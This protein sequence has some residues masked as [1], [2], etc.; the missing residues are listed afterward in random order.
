[1]RSP[2][3]LAPKERKNAAHGAS[4]GSEREKD[5]TSPQSGV[6]ELCPIP[7]LPHQLEVKISRNQL[8]ESPPFANYAK[9][10]AT[11]L[12]AVECLRKILRMI[13][14]V[15]S[16]SFSIQASKGVYALLLGS[17]LSTA[18]GIPTGWDVT[19]DLIRKTAASE[20]IECGSDPEAWYRSRY[21]RPA[22]YSEI[23]D[24]LAKTP[25]D[26]TN[27][28]ST[29]F[30]PSARDSE[31]EGKAPTAAHKSIA[32]LVAKGYL[33]VLVTTNFDRLLELA[34]ENEGISPTVIST[35]DAA[36]GALP[37]AHARCTVVKVN[38]DYRDTRIKNTLAE[39]EAYETEMDRLLD[40]I[41]DEY[42]LIIC[43]W[44]ATWDKAL[45]RA[46]LRCPNRR[47]TTYWARRT[48]LTEQ[49]RA[50][51]NHRQAIE[52]PIESADEFFGA[53]ETKL[54][55]I[56]RYSEPHPASAKLAIAS[57]K[58]FIAEDRYRIQLHDLVSSEAEDVVR[59]ISQLPVSMPALTVEEIFERLKLY[60]ATSDTLVAML[61]HGSFWGGAR[62]QPLW[63]KT[64]ARLSG[65]RGLAGGMT[66]LLSL[67][68]YPACL[69]FYALGLGAIAAGKY[70]TLVTI[71][72]DTITQVEGEEKPLISAVLPWSVLDIGVARQLPGYERDYTPIN[73]RLFEVLRD[74]V[75]DYLPTDAE[76]EDAFDRFEYLTCL[77][78]LDLRMKKSK[79]VHAPAG[80]FAW[81]HQAVN[82][83]DRISKES[84]ATGEQWPPIKSR[85]FASLSRFQE[86]EAAYNDH[87]LAKLEW[88]G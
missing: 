58:K 34:L 55:A 3:R 36:R 4:R 59:S 62:E 65:M 16:L 11:R 41:F 80:R 20:G 52:I 26:R 49:A 71:C 33:Q 27:L 2:Q 82:I 57:L 69:L 21:G 7:C 63:A 83:V 84:A 48:S 68:A 79:M 46:V 87:I 38:G 40:R 1:V 22:N 35:A 75:R 29:Y 88:Y 19:L 47:F 56:E 25:A 45:C 30:E 42:G 24:G 12:G 86:L 76:Y 14:A 77:V 5:H 32:R 44:S 18:A 13:D 66:H 61:A 85:L 78:E 28:L 9:G 8:Q 51:A 50:L 64:I 15:T 60:E 81:K 43:G 6:R 70:E 67:R 74:K 72:G 31:Q 39:L 37:L 17:G 10:C 23:I 54:D 73:N 53:L